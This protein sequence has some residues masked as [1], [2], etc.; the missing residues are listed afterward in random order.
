MFFPS[1]SGL[2]KLGGRLSGGHAYVING[3]DTKTKL[4]RIKNS[5]GIN[6]G[7]QGHAFISFTDMTRLIKE[8]GEIC[9]AI[10][11]NF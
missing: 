7:Q 11:N 4:F 10:E 6:W 2:I 1:K 8:R 5:W 3:V 9:L